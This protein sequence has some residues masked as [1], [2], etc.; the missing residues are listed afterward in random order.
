[1]N[2]KYFGLLVVAAAALAAIPANATPGS[3][4]TGTILARGQAVEK[5]KS[6]GND[7]YDVVVQHISIAPGGQTGWH[8]HPGNALA[9]I[10]SGALT[11]YDGD[12]PSCTARTFQAGEVYL[13]PGR[14]H[15]HMGRNE[16]T[17]TQLEILV[18]Y[19]DVPLGGGIRED[20]ANP[21][22]CSF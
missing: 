20:A 12:D 16:S 6:H 11:I 8:T 10:K 21:G 15:V 17:T 3:G 14:G 9:V 7:P 18:T 5:V 1:M 4:A 19:L 2:R 22:N 13:D